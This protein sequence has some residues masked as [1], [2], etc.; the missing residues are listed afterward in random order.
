MAAK[1][2]EQFSSHT[3]HQE[4]V[5]YAVR[6]ALRN[7][8]N[9]RTDETIRSL[10]EKKPRNSR[11]H[12]AYD[13]LTQKIITQLDNGVAPWVRPWKNDGSNAMPHNA[14]TKR[15]Y[16]NSNVLALWMA[17]E[18]RGFALPKW[19][20]FNQ[21]RK[22]GGHV[23]QGSH[24]ELVVY[25]DRFR[26]KE[27]DK[28]TGEEITK[29]I[30]FLKAFTVF[31]IEQIEGVDWKIGPEPTFNSNERA[32]EFLGAQKADVRYGG[33]FDMNQAYYS[34]GQDYIHL[35]KPTL[36]DS[37]EAFYATSLH[38]HAHWTGAKHRLDRNIANKFGGEGYAAEEL[39]AEL[40]S[41]FLCA[42]LHLDGKLR[43]PEYLAHW[44][45]VLGDHKGALLTACSAAKKSA[46]YL[47]G[48][49][50][51]EV[52]TETDDDEEEDAA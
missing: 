39:V 44:S 47:T 6:D 29:S 12:E 23:K 38:E 7:T 28:Q 40:T 46:D 17:Q 41:A 14:V 27:R 37:P 5:E 3:Q 50:Q 8:Y 49:W 42:D 31:N 43:H 16:N 26:I 21:A 15:P 11:A 52:I 30:P 9:A 22:A 19:L 4:Q 18:V 24:G 45:K 33:T 32:E 35:P 20:T 51:P 2:R 1:T 25:A 36:F 10:M 48:N 34:P 13:Q